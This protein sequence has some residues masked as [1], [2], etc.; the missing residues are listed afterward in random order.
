MTKIFNS[1]LKLLTICI[2]LGVA[3]LSYSIS[4]SILLIADLEVLAIP[5]IDNQD[6][7]VDLKNQQII[8]Y[9]PSPEDETRTFLQNYMNSY[10]RWVMKIW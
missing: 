6:P 7:F 5:V 9:G 3:M 4:Q 1:S 2:L 8:H 10:E